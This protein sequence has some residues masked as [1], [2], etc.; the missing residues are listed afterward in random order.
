[1][2]IILSSTF[3]FCS[4]FQN[5]AGALDCFDQFRR[6][7]QFP[8]FL[9]LL[10]RTGTLNSVFACGHG[11][12]GF[13]HVIKQINT[14]QI[15]FAFRHHDLKNRTLSW[16]L[17]F[18]SF[19]SN[20]ARR[21]VWFLLKARHHAFLQTAAEQRLGGR[22]YIERTHAI[23]S[24]MSKGLVRVNVRT[25][26][27]TSRHAILM[28]CSPGRK[29]TG[30]EYATRLFLGNARRNSQYR[31]SPACAS[32]ERS[33]RTRNSPATCKPSRPL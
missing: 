6:A 23:N 2:G 28:L 7:A 11:L 21:S 26:I 12:A 10:I 25:S 27:Q 8:N 31:S 24:R 32:Q 5:V 1:M 16:T 17:Q 29:I 15:Y 3:Q 20:L 9:F 30:V 4:R 18:G 33:N 19:S 22:R 14:A 13:T